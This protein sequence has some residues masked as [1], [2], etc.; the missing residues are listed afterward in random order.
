MS[1]H[2]IR[3]AMRRGELDEEEAY[4][5]LRFAGRIGYTAAI[6]RLNPDPWWTRARQ[7]VIKFLGAEPPH[8][9]R[10]D[11][12][13]PK[14]DARH[15]VMPVML[16]GRRVTIQWFG[17]DV[18]RLCIHW[19][20]SVRGPVRLRVYVSPDGTPGSATRWIVGQA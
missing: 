7:W 13:M 10:W 12:G 4:F 15:G 3:A 6:R 14:W 16:F 20:Q 5:L 19:R 8:L 9:S 18:G 1:E 11:S 17:V 2:S